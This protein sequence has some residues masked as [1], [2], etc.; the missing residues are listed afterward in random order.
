MRPL[1]IGH[2]G[3]PGYLPEH[4]AASYLQA[5]ALGADAVETDLVMSRD[6]VLIV[7]HEPE[8]SRTTDVATRREFA[9]RRRTSAVNGREVTGWFAHDFTLAELRSLHAPSPG[10]GILTFD[11]LLLAL[12]DAPRHVGLHV[13]LKI[14]SYFSQ[15]GLPVTRSLLDSLYDHGRDDPGSG[16]WIQSFDGGFLEH[17]GRRTSVPLMQ[18][19]D[20]PRNLEAIAEYADAIGPSVDLVLDPEPTGL[21]S[22]AHRAGLE[23]YCWTLTNS[24]AQTRSV[25]AEGVDGVFTDFPDLA[26]R[27]RQMERIR[28]I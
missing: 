23:V 6:G 15:M 9:N 22:R 11:E 3:A 12:A 20:R 28:A 5:I 14:P 13:E 24:V 10:F 18:L 1:V 16:T 27:A 25:L 4:S 7:R 8:L 19:T 17:I 21:V 2:R 26:V